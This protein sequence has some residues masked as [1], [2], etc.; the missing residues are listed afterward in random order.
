MEFYKEKSGD[1]NRNWDLSQSCV[2]YSS[3]HL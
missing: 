3:M 1:R 2:G